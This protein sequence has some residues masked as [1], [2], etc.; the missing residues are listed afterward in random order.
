MKNKKVY[1]IL[2]VLILIGSLFLTYNIY[3]NKNKVIKTKKRKQNNLA[4]MIK[5]DGATDYTKSNSKDIPKGNYVLNRDKSYCKNNGKIGEYDSTLGKVSFSFIGTDSCYL[6][7]DYDSEP[8]GY[9]KI[10]LDNGNGATTVNEAK[11][12]IEGK[13]IPDFSATATTNEGMYAKEDDYTATTGMKSYYFRGAVDNNWVKFGKYIKDIYLAEY[14]MGYT[15]TENCEDDE[16]VL[17]CKKIY[18]IGDDIYWRIIRINGDGSVRMIYTG[19]TDPKNDLSVSESKGVLMTGNMT[20][21]ASVIIPAGVEDGAGYQYIYGQQHGY[22][23][24]NSS[25]ESCTINGN[26][27]Y[28]GIFKQTLDKWY[29]M[30]TLA[31]TNAT[32]IADQIFCND[33]SVTDGTWSSSPQTL[34]YAAYTR[35]EKEKSPILTCPESSDRF[36]VNEKIGN[37]SLNYPVGLIN[38]DEVV[39]GGG[40][41]GKNSYLYTNQDYATG[42]P[43]AFSYY[44]AIYAVN[45]LGR[46]TSLCTMDGPVGMRPVISISQYAKFSGDGTYNNVYT[47]VN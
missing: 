26:V 28:N 24:C 8:K 5:E 41:G 30:T 10:L 6:Y 37:G 42:S 11:A 36:T 38:I 4:I 25:N 34:Y 2:I 3:Q 33:R 16:H 1:V 15:F 44:A 21:I 7:F 39:M 40:D 9:E 19:A 12:Y 43:A 31:T 23:K 32:S 46:S 22:G 35:I 18:S 20:Q 14:E 29:E 17:S 45:S 13:G 27:V 47:V